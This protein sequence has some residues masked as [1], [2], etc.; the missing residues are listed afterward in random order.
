MAVSGAQVDVSTTAVALNAADSDGQAGQ[1]LVITNKDADDL[2]VHLGAS[3]VD[4]GGV[5]GVKGYRLVKD[6]TV[7][8]TLSAGEVLYGR[9]ASGTITLDVLRLGV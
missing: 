3:T 9:T 1:T 5:A 8:V 4:P 6:A 2:P 7:T